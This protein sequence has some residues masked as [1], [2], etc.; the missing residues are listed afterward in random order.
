MPFRT[1]VIFAVRQPSCSVTLCHLRPP[2]SLSTQARPSKSLN[3]RAT[4]DRMAVDSKIHFGKPC[5][6]GTRITVQDVL[7]LVDEDLPLSQIIRD[8]YPDFTVEDIRACI[9]AGATP[10]AAHAGQEVASCSAVH[11]STPPI[12]RG[13]PRRSRRRAPPT[14]A[15][16]RAGP[17]RRSAKRCTSTLWRSIPCSI[18][19]SRISASQ[20]SIL[21]ANTAPISSYSRIDGNST[22][23]IRPKA[24]SPR[25]KLSG[26]LRAGAD[27]QPA[28]G[29]V[30]RAAPDRAVRHARS[31][32]DPAHARPAGAHRPGTRDTRGPGVTKRPPTPHAL[33]VPAADL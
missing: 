21:S 30:T 12:R 15:P 16:P 25:S 31:Q 32:R 17:N 1:R 13:D 7:E 33:P 29:S 27:P 2:S 24:P 14:A 10:R 9:S 20:R 26:V 5:V 18:P 6:A 11:G 23:H 3:S 28:P 19:C 22:R 4:P 8:Y